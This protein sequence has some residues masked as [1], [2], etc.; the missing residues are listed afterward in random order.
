MFQAA[1]DDAERSRIR[2]QLYAPPPGYRPSGRGPVAGTP[3]SASALLAQVAAE[4]AALAAMRP[5]GR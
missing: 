4:D 3:T 5:S 2:A 1:E